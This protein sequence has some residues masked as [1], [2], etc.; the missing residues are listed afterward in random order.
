MQGLAHGLCSF[1]NHRNKK[2]ERHRDYGA[3]ALY[4]AGKEFVVFGDPL[5]R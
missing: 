2:P 3:V 5:A 4:A 1:L